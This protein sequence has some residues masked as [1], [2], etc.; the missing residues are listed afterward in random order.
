[1]MYFLIEDDKSLKKY[2][3][4]WAKFSAGIKNKFD[5]KPVYSKNF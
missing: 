4:A 2:N 3:S 1:M 5:S